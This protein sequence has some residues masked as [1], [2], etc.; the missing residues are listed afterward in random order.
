MNKEMFDKLD[1][2]TKRQ[3]KDL[4]N[5]CNYYE[6]KKLSVEDQKYIKTKL[7]EEAKRRSE[8]NSILQSKK[9]DL[10]SEIYEVESLIANLSNVI[11]NNYMSFD[12]VKADFGR[13]EKKLRFLKAK[14]EELD[15]ELK[16]N[17]NVVLAA[18]QIV[19]GSKYSIARRKLD[20]G[21]KVVFVDTPQ[22]ICTLGKN[23]L[24]KIRDKSTMLSESLDQRAEAYLFEN[25]EKLISID[26]SIDELLDARNNIP[27]QG[28]ERLLQD[29][30]INSELVKQKKRFEKISK[31]SY[32]VSKLQPGI[33]R[34]V[35]M[36]AIIV[37]KLS[38]KKNKTD[39][40]PEIN[41]GRAI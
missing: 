26:N 23:I 38:D 29:E 15:I 34:M 5:S 9:E 33:V 20:D 35:N 13:L 6:M 32:V 27:K 41:M 36:P 31:K 12:G 39:F 30:A 4:L 28:Y 8:N 40:E 1:I 24:K 21:K 18:E 16:F 37:N 25:D 7:E 14:Q 10:D 3:L 2:L 19:K 17:N 11:N 22:K